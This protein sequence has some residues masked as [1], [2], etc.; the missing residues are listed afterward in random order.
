MIGSD[1]QY[2][3][4]FDLSTL[5][6]YPNMYSGSYLLHQTFSR[7]VVVSQNPSPQSIHFDTNTKSLRYFGDF[8]STLPDLVLTDDVSTTTLHLEVKN[9]AFQPG[10][11]VCSLKQMPIQFAP[12][13]DLFQDEHI[14]FCY[15]STTFS[16]THEDPRTVSSKYVSISALFYVQTTSTYILT[17]TSPSR[18]LVYLDHHKQPLFDEDNRGASTHHITIRLSQAYHHLR[19]YLHVY[20]L[21]SFALYYHSIK[22][23]LVQRLLA[24]DVLYLPPS[25]Q[26]LPSLN[27]FLPS[28]LFAHAPFSTTLPSLLPQER[29]CYIGRSSSPNVIVT[30]MCAVRLSPQDEAWMDVELYMELTAGRALLPAVRIPVD[31]KG[32]A[33]IEAIL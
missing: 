2:R 19:A 27:S 28:V 30:P 29:S 4:W 14:D 6:I 1:E 13:P 25:A 7:E 12:D 18:V 32:V 31:Q 26:P 9:P 15:H 16:F 22:Q 5:Y 17:I 24:D 11:R 8:N 21:E 3:S 23:D 10:V 33:G 20:S